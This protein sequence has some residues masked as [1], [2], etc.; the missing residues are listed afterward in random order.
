MFNPTPLVPSPLNGERVRV[1]GGAAHRSPSRSEPPDLPPLT[2]ALSPL[3]GEGETLALVAQ[4]LARL[5]PSSR[6][7]RVRGDAQQRP[8]AEQ[9]SREK[10]VLSSSPVEHSRDEMLSSAGQP[11]SFHGPSAHLS[12]ASS[13]SDAFQY[14]IL[15]SAT[16]PAQRP[17]PDARENRVARH[18]VPDCSAPRH[19]RSRSSAHQLYVGGET[20]TRRTD[21]R[22]GYSRAF[23]RPTSISFAAA[24][25]GWWT[26]SD[27][28]GGALTAGKRVVIQPPLT[29]A[30]SPLRGE[31]TATQRLEKHS[32]LSFRFTRRIDTAQTD[33]GAKQRI[34][35]PTAPRRAPSPLNGGE[36]GRRPDEGWSYPRL[37]L[38]PRHV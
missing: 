1:R 13:R 2:P 38:T 25:R 11:K 23:S 34:D 32:A 31:G 20:Y 6:I 17:L 22:E 37:R 10:A 36:G 24:V 16:N 29:L 27:L 19:N 7:K 28:V 15:F 8:S 14:S 5:L 18:P 35:R 9:A 30:L 12:T 3:R 21:G 26:W 4:V 33:A